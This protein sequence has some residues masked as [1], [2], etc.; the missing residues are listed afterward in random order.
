MS[1]SEK[2]YALGCEDAIFLGLQSWIELADILRH[3]SSDDKKEKGALPASAIGD[4][5]KSKLDVLSYGK[6]SAD[7]V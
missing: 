7:V 3:S 6:S 5:S 4:M 2:R 1:Y